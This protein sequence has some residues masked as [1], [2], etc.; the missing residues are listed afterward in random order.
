MERL[1]G[2]LERASA[3]LRTLKEALSVASP[4]KLER[5]GTKQRFEYTF[6]IFWK[7]CQAY[8]EEI[9]GIRC[10]SPKT[11]LR[12]LGPVGLANEAQIVALL[13]ATNDRNLTVDTYRENVAAGIYERLPDYAPVFEHVLNQM[14]TRTPSSQ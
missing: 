5:D 7:A 6:E 1:N 11:C 8:L 13:S 10:A 14:S 12:E 4:S 9:E 2:R 3:A